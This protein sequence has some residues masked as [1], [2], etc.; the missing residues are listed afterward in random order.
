MLSEENT[1]FKNFIN[2]LM[3]DIKIGKV[4]SQY[5]KILKPEEYEEYLKRKR[6]I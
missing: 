2:D 6:F 1:D 4:K 5:D 3:E